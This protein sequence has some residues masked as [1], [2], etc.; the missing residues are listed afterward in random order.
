MEIA[1][2]ARSF[3]ALNLSAETLSSVDSMG[4]QA[5]TDVQFET[6]P[7]ALA[8]KDLVV[9]SRTGTG[10][11]AAF[12]IPMVERIDPAADG[13]QG[14]A[15]APT[16]ELAL[17]V[18]AELTE[19]GRAKGVKVE[20]IYGG[21]SMERQLEG[22]RA[23]AHVIVGTPGRVLDHLRRKTLRFESVKM[24]VLDEADR[25]L[26]M[27]FA[28]EMGQIMEYMPA[29]RQSLLFSAT[30]PLGIR[31]LI[32]HYL[33]EPEWV[34]LSED[35]IY[36]KEVEHLYCLTP[37][38]HKEATVY[39]L[40]E[41]ENPASSMIFC[42]TREE[43][44]L[45]YTFLAG[46]GLAASM[47]SSDLPQK[48]REKVMARFRSGEIRH[49]VTTDVA[50]RGIDI[51]DLSHVF[52]FSTPDSPEQYIHRAGR[53]GRVGKSGR[54]ISLVSAH[55]LMNFNR[56]VKRYHVEVRELPVP[57]DQEVVERK[58]ER[59][60]TRLAAEGQNL[61]LEDFA[62]FSPIARRVADHEHRDRIVALLLRKYFEAPPPEEPEE[63]APTFPPPASAGGGGDGAPGG[64]RRRRR[65]R[66]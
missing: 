12:G 19:I 55:D 65:H 21:D 63:D 36:V 16:R 37:R 33:T 42:N 62:E 41:Y 35:Q 15:L 64:F 43:T 38:M 11:T 29:Q 6:I 40:L 22:I 61:P 30:I 25:M 8:G 59:L 39:K 14:V 60:V 31:G 23:G 3:A 17:Q 46:K 48:K 24:L 34:L 4:Y 1:T 44:R 56:L 53:T 13:I 9:Q 20:S 18:A 45:V 58:V 26:D 66:R 28:V 50:S 54:A 7:R 51:E 47:L 5:P 10:K 52:I 2:T 57:S 27:G 49:L 32:Y